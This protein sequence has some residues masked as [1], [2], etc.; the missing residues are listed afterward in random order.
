[1]T[2]SYSLESSLKSFNQSNAAP[3]PDHCTLIKNSLLSLCTKSAHLRDIIA[4]QEEAIAKLSLT[5]HRYEESREEMLFEQSRVQNLIERHRQALSSPIRNLPIDI[6]REIFRLA[7]SNAADVT[8]FPWTATHI[9]REWRA[10]ATQT[11]TLWSK[12]HIITDQKIGI[13]TYHLMHMP[14]LQSCLS[15][16]LSKKT[17]GCSETVGR[18]LELSGNV[19]LVVSFL[20]D[21]INTEERA[22]SDDSKMLD[23][24]LDHT[25]RW[26][27]AYLKFYHCRSGKSFGDRFRRLRGR[28]PMLE[29]IAIEASFYPPDTN[30]FLAVAP[31]LSTVAIRDH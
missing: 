25:P 21:V 4:E 28:V 2:F 11:L 27:V 7:S 19:L 20:Q 16:K 24:L 31:Q 6:M 29:R 3:S 22:V 9:C 1:M 15:S 26:K 12:I 5:L 17:V 30:E 8:D 18:A 23:L 10:I 13:R 14:E